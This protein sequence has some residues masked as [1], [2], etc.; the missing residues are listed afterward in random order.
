M[1]RPA[2]AEV[3]GPGDSGSSV[4]CLVSKVNADPVDAPPG[5]WFV[6]SGDGA[7]ENTSGLLLP[8]ML[9]LEPCAREGRVRG[10]GVLDADTDAEGMALVRGLLRRGPSESSGGSAWEAR[11]RLPKGEFFRF[12]IARR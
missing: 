3:E 2:A 12:D 4:V 9:E 1:D 7:T 5:V 11:R 8:L 6:V 10:L